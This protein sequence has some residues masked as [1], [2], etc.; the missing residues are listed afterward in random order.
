MKKIAAILAAFCV[1]MAVS[2]C[3]TGTN[4]PTDSSSTDAAQTT[5]A[6]ENNT[7]TTA[8][9]EDGKVTEVVYAAPEREDTTEYSLRYFKNTVPLFYDYL[10]IRRSIPLTMETETVYQ[11]KTWVSGIYIKDKNNFV[12]YS[13]DPDGVESRVIYMNDKAYEINEK[14]KIIYV[15]ECGSERIQEI[16]SS[17][18]LEVIYLDEA[19]ASLYESGEGDYEGTTYKT[20]NINTDD[21]ITTHYFDKSTG[22]LKYTVVGDVVTK[23]NRLENKFDHEEMFTLPEGYVYKNFEDVLEEEADTRS[24]AA[25]ISEETPESSESAEPADTTAAAEE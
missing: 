16:L 13:K 2:G 8:K 22:G 18:R 10:Q 21:V 11:G 5:S 12:Q 25:P 20:V 24:T 4:K 7:T 17:L 3:N 1:I 14:E 15:L 6:P 9:S 23:V 19:W